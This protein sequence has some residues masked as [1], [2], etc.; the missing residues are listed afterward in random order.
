MSTS[1]GLQEQQVQFVYILILPQALLRGCRCIEVDVWDGHPQSPPSD[2]DGNDEK[3]HHFSWHSPRAF[4]SGRG[5]KDK[6]KDE[7]ETEGKKSHFPLPHIRRQET[8]E[9]PKP[10][11][12]AS[13]APRTE[14]TVVHG[15]TLTKEISFRDVCYAIRDAAFV[16]R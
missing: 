1:V 6:D 8:D 5:S 4:F 10:W 16:T 14:P 9:M 2:S 15:Y 3:K 12:S 7:K 13:S 11:T